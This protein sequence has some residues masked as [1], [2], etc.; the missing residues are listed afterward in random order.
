MLYVVF[1]YVNYLS[2]CFLSLWLYMH[3][4]ASLSLV[5]FSFYDSVFVLV[6]ICISIFPYLQLDPYHF[7]S[8]SNIY[9]SIIY[10]YL[11]LT[12][13]N[14][15]V[16]CRYIGLSNLSTNISPLLYKKTARR[17][18]ASLNVFIDFINPPKYPSTYLFRLTYQ[19]I[20]LFVRLSLAGPLGVENQWKTYVENKHGKPMNP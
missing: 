9:L 13:L 1:T 3:M 17:F 5:V 12:L 11:N 20:N 10:P 19:S 18:P 2:I 6:C 4:F 7:C 8:L 14:D 16:I 15:T